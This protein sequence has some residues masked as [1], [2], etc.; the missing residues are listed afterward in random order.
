[1]PDLII[2]DTHL[3]LQSGLELCDKI[4]AEPPLRDVPLMFLSASQMPDII[5]RHHEAGGG[6]YHL[7]KPFDPDVLMKLVDRALWAPCVTEL[8]CSVT[9]GVMTP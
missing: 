5:R 8:H 3:G 6:A 4:K 1:V 2:C 7:R 9:S